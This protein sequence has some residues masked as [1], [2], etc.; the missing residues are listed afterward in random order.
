MRLRGTGEGGVRAVALGGGLRGRLRRGHAPVRTGAGSGCYPS[1]ETNRKVSCM[2]RRQIEVLEE[3][4]ARDFESNGTGGKQV[5][6]IVALEQVLSGLV[7]VRMLGI[8]CR[9]T[10]INDLWHGNSH[11][12]RVVNSSPATQRSDV[13]DLPKRGTSDTRFL[14]SPCYHRYGAREATTRRPNL[15]RPV[16]HALRP[17]RRRKRRRER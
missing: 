1:S 2:V 4:G 12:P 15:N 3:N 17:T 11:L 5:E 9:R 7:W 13:P 14:P 10:P 16:A 8:I 6:G